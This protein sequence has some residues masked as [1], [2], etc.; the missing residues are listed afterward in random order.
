MGAE[1]GRGE[2]GG[3]QEGLSVWVLAVMSQND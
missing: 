1:N 3:A 2:E